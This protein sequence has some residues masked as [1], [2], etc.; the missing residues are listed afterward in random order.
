MRRHTRSSR[1]PTRA[2]GELP[3]QTYFWAAAE[4][5]ALLPVRRHVTRTLGIPKSHVDITGYWHLVEHDE[6]DA[7]GEAAT[8]DT[9]AHEHLEPPITWFA[10]R[11]A[12]R[13]GVLDALAAGP[14]ERAALSAA[15]N[16]SLSRLG[17][18]VPL[19]ERASI[20]A[21]DGERI[22]LGAAG[23]ALVDDEHEREE[24]D[25]HLAD[26]ILSLAG[27]DTALRGDANTWQQTHDRTLWSEA[28]RDAAV[29]DELIE[30]AATL[31]YLTE[32]LRGL[33]AWDGA[34]RVG[35]TGPGAGA[36]GRVLPPIAGASVTVIEHGEGLAALRATLGNAPR[37][38][39]ADAGMD[40][41]WAP[42]DVAVLAGALARRT[43][44]EADTLFAEVASGCPV[45][46]V[47]EQTSADELDEHAADENLLLAAS[48]GSARRRPP[49]SPR[50][51]EP[52]GGALPTPARS[53]GATRRS[54][55][56]APEWPP[57]RRRE[58]EIR[59]EQDV[60]APIVL[61][62]PDLL[63]SRA[64]P[65]EG[66]GRMPSRQATGCCRST[67]QRAPSNGVSR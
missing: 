27:L 32:A 55:S 11:A 28:T 20:V 26:L 54:P 18:L 37:L 15:T 46:V 49:T 62:S 35:L 10:V 43:D 52:P 34:A 9:D 25:G 50:S 39:Y 61:F 6:T 23:E 60:L 67:T 40:A 4:S 1:S 65:T 22:A 45:A 16:V 51:P 47:I 66:R 59:S 7:S 42:I 63:F 44:S 53:D 19:L 36:I 2:R 33:R 64:S 57:A 24:F 56:C 58:Q 13:L 48:V 41:A 17:A 5:R 30:S 3:E 12:L 21:T 8:D 38:E 29:Y 14:L 31:A